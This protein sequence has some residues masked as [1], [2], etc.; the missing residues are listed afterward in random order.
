MYLRNIKYDVSVRLR[1]RSRVKGKAERERNERITFFLPFFFF[2]PLPSFLSFRSNYSTGWIVINV[3]TP[4]TTAKL[5][6]VM[7]AGNGDRIGWREKKKKKETME[8]KR[9][10][11]VKSLSPRFFDR[12][13]YLY[14]R[15]ASWPP[16]A[17][18]TK[19]GK[20]GTTA[21]GSR[22]PPDLY[23]FPVRIYISRCLYRDN[24]LDVFVV[25]CCW[26]GR[27]VKLSNVDNHLDWNKMWKSS[28]QVL[29]N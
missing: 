7:T 2:S 18:P 21:R 9:G 23:L 11:A 3:I 19:G 6:A 14:L 20:I 16:N 12:P 27:F 24:H 17:C 15:P 8:E 22:P 13:A 25:V 4:R 29:Y 26:H 1:A 10:D 28:S 5:R